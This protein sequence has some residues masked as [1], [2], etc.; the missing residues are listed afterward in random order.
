MT[1]LRQPIKF[2]FNNANYSISYSFNLLILNCKL[3]LI[4]R[5]MPFWSYCGIIVSYLTTHIIWS[6]WYFSDCYIVRLSCLS[7]EPFP[8]DAQLDTL[9]TRLGQDWQRLGIQLGLSLASIDMCQDTFNHP[10]MTILRML[11]KWRDQ[12]QVGLSQHQM[13][14]HL[15]VSYHW[16]ITVCCNSIYSS[17]KIN[18]KFVWKHFH[19]MFITSNYKQTLLIF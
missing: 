1:W 8:S 9:T 3:K 4:I 2:V 18:I 11:I 17:N 12:S 16:I 15:Q 13:I 6:Q 14:S 7:I 19:F 5:T 10:H